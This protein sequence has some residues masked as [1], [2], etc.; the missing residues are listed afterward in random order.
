MNEMTGFG[1]IDRFDVG[2]ALIVGMVTTTAGHIHSLWPAL[3]ALTIA[4]VAVVFLFTRLLFRVAHP[5]GKH[6][7]KRKHMPGGLLTAATPLLRLTSHS[8]MSSFRWKHEFDHLGKAE[9]LERLREMY[10]NRDWVN[11]TV[12]RWDRH[13]DYSG[14]E[15]PAGHRE[16][17]HDRDVT[18]YWYEL[19]YKTPA[20]KIAP[21]M[22]ERVMTDDERWAQMFKALP[23]AF[24]LDPH[25]WEPR[26]QAVLPVRPADIIEKHHAELSGMSIPQLRL[27]M[28]EQGVSSQQFN[29]WLGSSFDSHFKSLP[30]YS[31]YGST[32]R[33]FF[34]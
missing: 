7:R 11:V 20:P 24:W 18:L 5:L 8:T 22:P 21:T 9:A 6:M 29:E 15:Q 28:V 26:K 30:L 10:H 14:H 34:Q 31:V 13:L 3:L 1:R 4:I 19:P 33:T 12:N 27:F 16:N 25:Y 23:I 17:L 2:L 32:T